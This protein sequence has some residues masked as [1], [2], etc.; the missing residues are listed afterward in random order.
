MQQLE[1]GNRATDRATRRKLRRPCPIVRVFF[2]APASLRIVRAR[3][4]RA[5]MPHP[6]PGVGNR[7]KIC[8]SLCISSGRR[9]AKAPDGGASPAALL[10]D[11]V[12]GGRCPRHF[13]PA[14]GATKL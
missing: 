11:A 2:P 5:T 12:G 8:K 13:L 10:P 9:N 14:G 6:E 3:S 4:N 1:C 7:S